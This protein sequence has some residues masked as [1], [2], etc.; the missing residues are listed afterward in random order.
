MA[1]WVNDNNTILLED[2]PYSDLW[3]KETIKPIS[4]QCNSKALYVGSFSKT[5]APSLRIGY[6]IAK[7]SFINR[8]KILRQG[9]DLY[10]S[11]IL[12]QMTLNYFHSY[13][14][15]NHKKRLRRF[16]KAKRG[17]YANVYR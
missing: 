7:E 17:Y 11:N 3:F 1:K 5:L 15:E 8:L 6:I 4:I 9:D 12:Q 10:S 13:N 2:D 16:Y 14:F